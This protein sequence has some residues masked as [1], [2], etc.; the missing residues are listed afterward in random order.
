METPD[1]EYKIKTADHEQIY[2]H[3]KECRAYFMP[4]LHEKTDV[5][6]YSKKL[7]EKAV[8][9]EAWSKKNLIGLIAAYFNNLQSRSGFITS[10]SVTRN[11]EGKGVASEL[12][13]MCIHYARQNSFVEIKLEVSEENKPAIH[14]YKKFEFGKFA[15]KNDLLIMKLDI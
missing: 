7:F 8:T 9:F 3:L 14:L 15:N 4:P 11:Y 12:L 5:L 10:V 6:E 1:L 2:S 13:R